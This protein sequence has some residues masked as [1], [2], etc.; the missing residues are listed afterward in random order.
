MHY[1]SSIYDDRAPC[2]MFV[3]MSAHPVDYRFTAIEDRALIAQTALW[4]C[5]TVL[6]RELRSL[7]TGARQGLGEAAQGASRPSRLLRSDVKR[8]HP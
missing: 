7:S 6:S 3:T 8:K 2:V 5:F 1:A 4:L